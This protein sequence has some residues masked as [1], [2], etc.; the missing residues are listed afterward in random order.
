M[1]PWGMKFRPCIDIHQGQVK[2]IV[3][4]TL[5]DDDAEGS[6]PVTNFAAVQPSTFFAEKYRQD[7]LTGGHIVMLGA[8]PESI[9][10]AK[11]ALGAYPGGMQ[12]GGGITVENAREYL[13]AGASHV[14]V[15]SHVFHGGAIDRERLS[16]LVETVG[17]S[18]LVL[19][20]SCRR[21]ASADGARPVY[22]VVTD[23]WQ[24]WTDLEV[25]EATLR[26]LSESCDEFL[27][28]GVDVEGLQSG[29]EEPLVEVLAS[30][31]IPV[32]YAGGVRSLADMERI[33]ELGGGRVDATIGSALDIFGGSLAYADV[34]SWHNSQQPAAKEGP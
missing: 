16:K 7:Q 28:H 34:L 18:R 32:T 10:S 22:K 8:T 4:G 24:K 23:R 30:S 33:R 17:R 13:E 5:R 1:L 9:T 15:T 6:G 19:D 2:Q 31:P 12:V 21:V 25:S 27:V 29:I 26:E 11:A 20:L 3:G 14:I